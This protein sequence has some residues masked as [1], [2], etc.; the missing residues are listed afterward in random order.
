MSAKLTV[1]A[2]AFRSNAAGTGR[3]AR[4]FPGLNPQGQG[5][6]PGT[7]VGWLT[8][9]GTALVDDIDGNNFPFPAGNH[10]TLPAGYTYLGQFIDHDLTLDPT[11]LPDTQIDIT[12]LN[13]FR[14]PAL[15]LDNLLG[16]GPGVDPVLYE[17]PSA[18]SRAG[19]LRTAAG[20][21]G[22]PDGIAHD[23]PRLGD[24]TPLIGDHRNDEN[25]LVGQ[26]HTAFITFFN[27]VF[28]DVAAGTIADLG[29][30]GGST[31]EKTAR[32]ARWHYQWI[33]LKDFLPR[34]VEGTILDYVVA[35]G[36][37]HYTPEAGSPYMPVEFAGAAYRLGHSMVRERYRVN[38]TFGPGN[39]AATLLNLFEFS[40]TV[41]NVPVPSNWFIN[42][43]RF[44]EIDPGTTVNL[45]RRLD[46]Y[47]APTLHQLP[48]RAPVSLAVRNLLRGWSWGLPSGQSIATHIGVQILTPEQILAD[49]GGQRCKEAGVVE[50]FNFH[51]DTPLWYYILKESETLHR[52]ERLGPVGSTILAEVFVGLLRADGESFL[53]INPGWTPT[54][55]TATAGQFTMADLFRYL[56]PEA[57]NPNGGD[58]GPV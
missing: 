2:A 13:N 23:L 44:F 26:L 57:L 54:L 35:N 30:V 29:P 42:W 50:P 53:S 39:Q 14:S 11:L 12:T 33:V 18:G 38:G 5:V 32:I 22:D 17:P 28:T 7:I 56:P 46:P 34:I 6:D 8:S 37:Q 16:F 15:D 1:E 40:S 51:N 4:L 27:K 24:G 10:P 52:G 55:P 19:R 47:S 48:I 9:L 3:F 25:L 58:T 45:A 36:P 21:A 49:T 41:G 43:N 31:S 20:L